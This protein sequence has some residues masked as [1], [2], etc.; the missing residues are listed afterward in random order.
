MAAMGCRR[1]SATLLALVLA[2]VTFRATPAAFAQMDGLSVTMDADQYKIGDTGKICYMVPGPGQVTITNN[3]AAGTITL[4]SGRD[5]GTGDCKSGPIQGPAG[6]YCVI[7][8]FSGP[9]GAGTAQTCYQVFDTASE[10]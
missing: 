8:I 4:F 5:D 1:I 10:N 3:S 2:T 9:V 7:V 6:K